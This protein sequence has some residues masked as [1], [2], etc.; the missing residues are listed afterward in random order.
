M[1]ERQITG[2]QQ[3]KVETEICE[4][5]GD[6]EWGRDAATRRKMVSPPKISRP[7]EERRCQMKV[8][9]MSKGKGVKEIENDES[10]IVAM[11]TLVKEE[12]NKEPCRRRTETGYDSQ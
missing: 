9:L 8:Q 4:P 11:T 10:K 7:H 12:R 3:E 6:G 1:D 2:Q 5:V